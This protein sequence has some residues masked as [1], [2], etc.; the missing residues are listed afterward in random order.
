MN[1]TTTS[2]SSSDRLDYLSKIRAHAET[3]KQRDRD[4]L[5]SECMRQH[6]V[7]DTSELT[8]IDLVFDILRSSYGSEATRAATLALR[9]IEFITTEFEMSHGRAPRGYGS[10]AFEIEGRAETFWH[11]GT[12]AEARRAARVEAQKYGCDRVMVGS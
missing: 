5:V 6:R 12:Y 9:D 10:W 1:S 11:T 3:L 8:K 4:E 2:T 7:Y